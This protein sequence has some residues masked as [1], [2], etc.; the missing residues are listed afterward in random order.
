MYNTLTASVKSRLFQTK[1]WA[2][3]NTASFIFLAQLTLVASI[4]LGLGIIYDQNFIKEPPQITIAEPAERAENYPPVSIPAAIIKNSTTGDFIASKS[5]KAYYLLTC[6]NNIKE[7]NK[8]YFHTKEEAGKAGFQPAKNCCWQKN[9][10][11]PA[12]S[13]SLLLVIRLAI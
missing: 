5:G 7:E 4:F 3:G 12:T 13:S 8:I 2:K 9:W 1:E 10:S 6:G 11:K